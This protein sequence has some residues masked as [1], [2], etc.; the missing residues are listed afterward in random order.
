[1]P[2]PAFVGE[3][4]ELLRPIWQACHNEIQRSHDLPF[5]ARDPLPLEQQFNVYLFV[6][7]RTTD[8]A[9]AFAQDFPMEVVR[10]VM[11]DAE[12][13]GIGLLTDDAVRLHP[14]QDAEGW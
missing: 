10:R 8:R 7:W 11:E 2:D 6:E 12:P 13:G 9:S 14:M 1:M 5:R 3:L 4:Y